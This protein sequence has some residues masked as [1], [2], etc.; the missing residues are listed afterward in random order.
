VG[1][2]NPTGVSSFRECPCKSNVLFW[3][4]EKSARGGKRRSAKRDS[5]SAAGTDQDMCGL[6]DK[7]RAPRGGQKKWRNVISE[8]DQTFL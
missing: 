4:T 8:E 3:M 7:K 6:A 2:A 5:K 1:E